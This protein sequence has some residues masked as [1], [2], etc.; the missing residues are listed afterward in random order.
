MQKPIAKLEKMGALSYNKAGRILSEFG[1]LR[2]LGRIVKSRAEAVMVAKNIGFPVALKIHSETILHK[3]DVGGVILGI[4]DIPSLE[5]A[6]SEM[7]GKFNARGFSEFILQKMHSGHSVIIGM[8]RDRQFG[9]VIVFGM[10]GIY[11]ELIKDASYRIAPVSVG[12][13]MGMVSEIRMFPILDGARGT[14]KADTKKLAELISRLSA[15]SI[16]RPE[17]KEIDL[18]P[19]I[20]N[21]KEAIAV[22]VKVII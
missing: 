22:D 9:P 14:V 21:D 11:V 3:T 15:M 6:Y 10:G 7:S 2:P 17:I 1:I 19:V 5:S 20:V 13:A 18:N 4:K 12:E 8:K 16:K